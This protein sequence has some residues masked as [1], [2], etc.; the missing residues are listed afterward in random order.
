LHIVVFSHPLPTYPH[1]F[2][3]VTTRDNMSGSSGYELLPLHGGEND[4]KKTNY[5]SASTKFQD[6][7]SWAESEESRPSV[8][9]FTPSEATP[10]LRLYSGK[11]VSAAMK[12]TIRR[13]SIL[14]ATVEINIDRS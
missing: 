14:I 10:M 13:E 3:R 7:E 9:R 4:V 5:L 12:A 2:A 1:F 8:W 11:D 6:D